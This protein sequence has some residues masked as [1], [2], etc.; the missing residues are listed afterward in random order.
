[1][2][3]NKLSEAIELLGNSKSKKRESG[4]KRLRKLADILSTQAAIFSSS[5]LAGTIIVGADEVMWFFNS[6]SS[7]LSHPS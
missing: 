5:F 2:H 4:A 7:I 1:M 6:H 3:N